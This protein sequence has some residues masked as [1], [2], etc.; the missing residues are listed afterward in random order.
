MAIFKSVYLLVFLTFFVINYHTEANNVIDV[1]ALNFTSEISDKTFGYTTNAVETGTGKSY[2]TAI[3]T[4][5]PKNNTRTF[6]DNSD[7]EERQHGEMEH[8]GR[9]NNA[10]DND[11]ASKPC[12]I[13]HSVVLTNYTL[14]DNGSL[15]DVS[16]NLLYPAGYFWTDTNSIVHG[17]ICLLK[18]C[19]RKCCPEG[20]TFEENDCVPS[21][22]PLL[23]PFELTF[24]DETTFEPLNKSDVDVHL[25]YG[26]P[27]DND[28]YVLDPAYNPEDMFFLLNTGTL[29]VPA[30][31]NS[32]LDFFCMEAFEEFGSILPLV[33]ITD[34]DDIEEPDEEEEDMTLLK[35]IGMIISLPFLLL[36]FLTYAVLENLRNLHGLSLMSY[37]GCLFIAYTFL[38]IIQIG[39]KALSKPFCVSCGELQT[40]YYNYS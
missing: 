35:P 2:V 36:T 9:H 23:Y 3:I 32:T 26:K 37:V 39:S 14:F 33:C 15:L 34:G 20:M 24:I 31:K 8:T 29:L 18:T 38:A 40:N 6:D 21:D 28:A 27:C 19:V 7:E 10:M 4:D 30:A 17:C 11:K 12:T 5:R 13:S 22:L 1:T 25:I 16:E